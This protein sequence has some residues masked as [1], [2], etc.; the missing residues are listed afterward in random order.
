MWVRDWR[1]G[2]GGKTVVRMQYMRGDFY[3]FK[4]N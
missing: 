3:F 2:G 1:E 4:K